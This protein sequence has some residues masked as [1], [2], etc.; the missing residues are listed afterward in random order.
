MS[1]AS[2]EARGWQTFY[3]R[4]IGMNDDAWETVDRRL[5]R[6]CSPQKVEEIQQDFVAFTRF[7]WSNFI[8]LKLDFNDPVLERILEARGKESLKSLGVAEE[9]LD[10]LRPDESP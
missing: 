10:A 7:V 3:D 9:N 4:F 2:G 5:A 8:D 1:K 6:E